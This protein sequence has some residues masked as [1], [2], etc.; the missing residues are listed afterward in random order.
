MKEEDKRKVT[1]PLK[2]IKQEEKQPKWF[3]FLVITCSII[4]FPFLCIW[5]WIRHPVFCFNGA[6]K[7]F[8]EYSEKSLIVKLFKYILFPWR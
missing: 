8:K 4:V 6:K 3:T 2:T 1:Q 7:D 5:M